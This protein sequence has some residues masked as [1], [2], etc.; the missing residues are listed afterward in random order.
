MKWTFD[1]PYRDPDNSVVSIADA[2]SEI[3]D[4]ENAR[5]AQQVAFDALGRGVTRVGDLLDELEAAGP[6][7][8]RALL[9]QARTNAGL[10]STLAEEQHRAFEAANSNP[11]PTVLRDSAGRRQALCGHEGCSTFEPGE[12]GPGSIAWVHAKRWYLPNPP[13]RPRE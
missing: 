1:L 8:R 10:R 13:R 3:L 2:A 6:D 11:P 9:D 12:M 5:V 4:G 7:G